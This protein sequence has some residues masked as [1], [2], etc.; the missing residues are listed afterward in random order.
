[1]GQST[2]I[3]SNKKEASKEDASIPLGR[4]N[5]IDFVGGLGAGGKG[6]GV[7][8]EGLERKNMGRNDWNWRTFKV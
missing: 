7:Y 1:M 4:G 6:T 2:E 5:R 3:L 8:G